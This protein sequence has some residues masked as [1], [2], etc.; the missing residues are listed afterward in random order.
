MKVGI[1]ESEGKHKR[2]CTNSNTPKAKS[3][4]STNLLTCIYVFTDKMVSYVFMIHNHSF[5]IITYLL[6]SE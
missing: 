5:F 4:A 2:L 3:N 1:I 6:F